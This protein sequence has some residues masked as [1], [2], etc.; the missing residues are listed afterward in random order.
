M[1]QRASSIA[2]AVLAPVGACLAFAPRGSAHVTKRSRALRGRARLGSGAALAGAENF[3]EVRGLR[4]LRGA[5]RGPG[6][7]ALASRS[8]TAARR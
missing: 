7:G 8:S 5:G 1:S 4:R 6:G 2:L 3:V